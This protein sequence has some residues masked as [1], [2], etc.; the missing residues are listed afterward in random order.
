MWYFLLF[1]AYHFSMIY[2]TKKLI[3]HVKNYKKGRKFLGLIKTSLDKL[4]FMQN[5]KHPCLCWETFIK[6][7]IKD[8]MNVI[9]SF[10][11]PSTEDVMSVH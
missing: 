10:N 9:T 6:A 4:R 5:F 2:T 3:A 1:L 8:M 11:A 7:T